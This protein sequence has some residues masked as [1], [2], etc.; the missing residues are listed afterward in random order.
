MV[1][2]AE[3]ADFEVEHLLPRPNEMDFDAVNLAATWKKWKQIMML[4]LSAVMKDRSEEERYSTVLFVDGE[5]GRE[6]FNTWTWDKVQD[7]DGNDTD[8][9]NITVGALFSLVSKEDQRWFRRIKLEVLK[10]GYRGT[11]AKNLRLLLEGD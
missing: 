9:D 7:D 10:E 8:V 3:D 11:S 5:S 4:F 1:P 6:I 2:E